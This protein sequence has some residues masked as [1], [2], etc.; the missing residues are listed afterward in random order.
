MNLLLVLFFWL[1]SGIASMDM[2]PVALYANVTFPIRIVYAID[3]TSVPYLFLSVS[4][5][6]FST[7]RYVVENHLEIY[8]VTS[9]SSLDEAETLEKTV[10]QKFKCFSLSKF[11]VMTFL[12][13]DDSGLKLSKQSYQAHHIHWYSDVETIRLMIPQILSIDR[14]I[15]FDNDILV[16]K[17]NSIISLWKQDLRG[18][19]VGMVLN[20]EYQEDS[21]HTIRTYFN[22]S[23]SMLQQ[24]FPPKEIKKPYKLTTED[25]L[26]IIPKM[27]NNG[28]MLV[29]AVKWRSLNIT[30]K[31]IISIS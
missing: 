25:F 10:S 3:N 11:S 15:Y 1:C 14:Y 16:T 6:I 5:I 4:S 24:I 23:N 17:N 20:Q 26:A 13:A 2:M 19:V 18:A 7:P 28:V 12:H 27:P 31:L 30:G 21:S 22:T 8:V 29:N 9:G